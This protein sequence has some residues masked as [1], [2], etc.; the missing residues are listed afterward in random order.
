MDLGAWSALEWLALAE[1]ELLLFAGA[2]FLVGALDEFAMDA[3]WGWLRLRGRAKTYTVNRSDLR[4]RALSGPIAVLIPAW[5]EARVIGRTIAHMVE[6]WPQDGLTFYIGCYRNDPATV[7]AAMEGAGGD[8]R[9]R[10]ILLD[11]DGPTTK[12]D[13]LNRLYA[14]MEGDELRSGKHT[15]TVL[16]HDAEDTV[17]AAA[18]ALIDRSMDDC[19]FVQLPVLA[20]PHPASP[21]V[22]SHYVEEFC[23]SHGKALMVRDA[24]GAAIPAAGVGCAFKRDTLGVMSIGGEGPFAGLSLTE[25]YELGLRIDAA[26]GRSRFL[27]VRGDD[28]ALV[29]TRSYFPATLRGAVRQKSRWMHGIAFQGWDRLGWSGGAVEHWMRMRDR[30]GPLSALV[31]LTGYLLFALALLLSVL[32]WAGYDRPWELTPA[33]WWLL[34]LNMAA[35]GWRAMMRF[36]FTAREYGA[37]EGLRAVLRIPLSNVIAIMAGRRALF[38]YART[39]RGAAPQWDKTSRDDHPAPTL[40][41][42]AGSVR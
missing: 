41:E 27:R 15:R 25:D 35:F 26:G 42:P 36:A 7:A 30:R 1:Y 34:A 24:L 37:M 13:C 4:Y 39:L 9:V 40:G 11:R 17:D 18:I 22:G 2:F 31:L 23:E 5:Q 33:L 3:A 21:W 29:A 16:L 19:E 12:A 14:A 10:L 32:D 8:P 20:L 38:A 6:V 28:G